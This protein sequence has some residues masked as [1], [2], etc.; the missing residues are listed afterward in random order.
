MTEQLKTLMDRAADRDFAAVDLDAITSAGDRSIRRRRV[1]T[2]VAGIAAVAV[3]ATGAVLLT[4]GDDRKAGFVDTTFETDVPMWT[5]GSILH[6]PDRTFDLGMPVAGI[7][8]TA[9]GI[10]FVGDDAGVYAF[11][12]EEPERI[13]STVEGDFP[14]L[15]ADEDGTRVAWIDPSGNEPELVVRDLADGEESRY[16]TSGAKDTAYVLAV[17]GETAYWIEGEESV[18]TDLGTGEETR[19]GDSDGVAIV[20]DAEDGLTVRLVE[21]RSGADQGMEVLDR[22]GE[23]LLGA[24]ESGTL[25][26]LSPDGRWVV[27]LDDPSV[28]DVRTGE[29]VALDVEG[30]D[31]IGY[32]WLDESRLMVLAEVDNDV[33]GLKECAVPAGTCSDVVEIALDEDRRF[34]IPAF[35]MLFGL[36]AGG[37]PDVSSGEASV[38][39]PAESSGTG[40]PE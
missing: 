11:T 37:D 4:G 38:P 34:S 6:T 15:V 40:R 10:A 5:E 30:R 19:A 26:S 9:V 7:A 17:E 39:A 24:P 28:W 18:V 31:A 13:G 8:R 35:G 14:T 23:V 12:G 29:Q 3:V 25:G 2:G 21:G 1:V 22:D 33:V 27:G 16:A 32:D 36:R 20:V